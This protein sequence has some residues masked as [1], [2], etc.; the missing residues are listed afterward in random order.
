MQTLFE[1][2]MHRAGSEPGAVLFSDARGDLTRAGLMA[3]AARLAARLPQSA[4][5]IGLLLPSGREWA[6]AQFACVAAGRTVVPLPTFFSPEQ[7]RHVL[8][9]A[10]VDL[11]L[12][13]DEAR[14]RPDEGLPC[15]P[16][17]VSGIGG[18]MP[19]FREGFGEVI[20]TSGS[21]G[22]PR[23]VRHESG[24][25]AWSAAA[26]ASAIS[27]SEKDSY[28]SV[29]PLS[30][31]LETICALFVPAFVGG[32][33]HFDAGLAEAVGRGAAGGIAAAFAEARPSI[34]VLVPELLRVWVAELLAAGREAPRSLRFV[35]VGGAHVPLHLADAAWQLGIP[36]HEGYGLSEC[37]SVVALNRPGARVAGTVGEP[38]PGLRVTIR[39]GEIVVEGPSVMDGYLG[40][41]PVP[42]AWATGDL[43]ALDAEGRLTVFGRRDNLVVT[44]LGRNISPEWVEASILDDPGIGWC[45]VDTDASGLAA[46]VIPAPS[47]NGRF[48]REGDARERVAARCAALPAYARPARVRVVSLAEARVCGL[49]TDNGRVRRHVAREFLA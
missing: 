19:T 23:G 11:L 32:R 39:G 49:L 7:S 15:M 43:G 46:L 42:R 1:V 5:T 10:R 33:T 38:L 30:L 2:L 31:L 26:L 27:A 28:L 44:P 24:Q 14:T 36:V 25:I 21:T 40:G 9:D 18:E 22:R 47:A 13:R 29:L 34:G 45:A 37:C 41:P 6:V 20:Y 16:V 4:R 12:V 8:N 48:E 3:D 17:A 35:A